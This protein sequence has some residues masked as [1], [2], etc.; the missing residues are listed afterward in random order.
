MAEGFGFGWG[1]TVY[2][3]SPSPGGTGLRHVVRI[4][5]RR[6]VV[7]PY[8]LFSGVLVTR[9]GSTQTLWRPTTGG[10]VHRGGVSGRPPQGG[11]HLP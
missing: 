8:F 9:S 10:G 7:I 6:V 2:S 11:R 5:F 4:G 1:E 3:A